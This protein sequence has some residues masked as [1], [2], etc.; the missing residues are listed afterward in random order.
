MTDEEII[1]AIETWKSQDGEVTLH[2]Y[3]MEITLL[4]DNIRAALE[5]R[6]RPS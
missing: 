4:I 5:A 3:A 6:R 1:A 2:Q